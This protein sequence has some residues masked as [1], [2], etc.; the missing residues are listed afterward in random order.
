MWHP[1]WCVAGSK[2][3]AVRVYE[4]C[5]LLWAWYRLGLCM[6]RPATSQSGCWL[7][8]KFFL[9]Q[10]TDLGCH[11]AGVGK[12]HLSNF[13][14]GDSTPGRKRKSQNCE[15]HLI[16]SKYFSLDV[17]AK[18]PLIREIHT[19]NFC[20]N[21]PAMSAWYRYQEKRSQSLKVETSLIQNSGLVTLRTRCLCQ[22]A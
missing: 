3:N 22:R 8:S 4:S 14:S 6:S 13:A 2:Q 7:T 1:H 18:K 17:K 21:P 16:Y 5:E 10:I 20:L 12:Q 19:N 11:K 15:W 9:L